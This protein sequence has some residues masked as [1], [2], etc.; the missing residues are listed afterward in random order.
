MNNLDDSSSQIEQYEAIIKSHEDA[1]REQ[2]EVLFSSGQPEAMW[3][4]RQ[5][6]ILSR[7]S[8]ATAPTRLLLADARHQLAAISAPILRL[9]T[10][11]IVGIMESFNVDN[12]TVRLLLV[13]KR[14]NAI[15]KATP[16]LWSKIA[17]IQGPNARHRLKGVHCCRSLEHLSSVLSFSG[18]TP[19]HIEVC[20]AQPKCVTER[21]STLTRI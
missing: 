10:E 14:W 8:K 15:A 7:A 21:T 12:P 5:R 3:E 19:L 2:V 18:A 13:S 9:P 11:C 16:Q 6:H 4:A 1:A 20:G 17:L